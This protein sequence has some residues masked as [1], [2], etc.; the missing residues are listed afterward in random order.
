MASAQ[1]ATQTPSAILIVILVALLVLGVIEIFALY[2]H[3]VRFT[4]FEIILLL[5]LPFFFYLTALPTVASVLV[6]AD[7]VAIKAIIDMARLLD[8][9]LLRFGNATLA[10]NLVGFSIPVFI[11][12]KMLLQKRIPVKESLLLV[13][14]I[15]VVSFLYTYFEPDKGMVIYM[16]A[17]P[18][19]L[20]AAIA[21][22]FKKMKRA[23][24]FN[25]AL[26]SYAGATLGI[27]I[28]ADV[29]NLYRALTYR[30][31][32]TV[33]ISVGGGSILDAI[34][35]A[36]I[37]ALLADLIFREQEENVFG[38]LAKLFTG[39]RHR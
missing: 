11:S 33:V 22:M 2:L 19:I 7:A 6:A 24:D 5:A 14:I 26:L 1:L 10:F 31:G 15:S 34:F 28:G 3:L 12:V 17:I 30:W 38:D 21:F 37:I 18:P 25:S 39:H 8:V 29:G 36:G 20:A 23:R 9:P 4:V 13:A 32:E 35:L 27:L 16:F